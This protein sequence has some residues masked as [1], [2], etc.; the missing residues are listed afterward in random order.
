MYPP[1]VGSPGAPTIILSDSKSKRNFEKFALRLELPKYI[2][3]VSAH[4]VTKD[5]KI[6]SPEAN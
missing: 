3:I 2:I 1:L 6:I 5:L 4:Y